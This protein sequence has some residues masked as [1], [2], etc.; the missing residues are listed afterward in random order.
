MRDYLSDLVTKNSGTADVLQPRRRARFEPLLP[1]SP[2]EAESE[3]SF[4]KETF[5]KEEFTQPS[6]L[7][8]PRRREISRI[9]ETP[10]I[11]P[12][13]DSNESFEQALSI[14]ARPQAHG[15]KSPPPKTEP[16]FS[17]KLIE[18]ARETI[19][20]SPPVSALLSPTPS[21]PIAPKIVEKQVKSE[22]SNEPALIVKPTEPP[23]KENDLKVPPTKD[24]GQKIVETRERIVIEPRVEKIESRV[25]DST[26]QQT[27]ILPPEKQSAKQIPERVETVQTSVIN[28]TIGRIE[29]RAAVSSAPPKQTPSKR[30]T[31]SLDEYLRNRGTGGRK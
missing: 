1:L 14:A 15:S 30:P 16:T 9:E 25:N 27:S 11:T 12:R 21:K 8:R 4:P 20:E 7:R 6:P 2:F 19:T 5:E 18:P 10:E 22:I 31:L 26:S 28:V 23:P 24:T 17:P 29:V 3:P 13:E